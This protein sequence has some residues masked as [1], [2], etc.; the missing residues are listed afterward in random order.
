LKV[1]AADVTPLVLQELKLGH[2]IICIDISLCMLHLEC[3]H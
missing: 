3:I 1:G 2:G